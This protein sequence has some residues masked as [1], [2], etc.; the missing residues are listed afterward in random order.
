MVLRDPDA[1]EAE[2]V[3]EA[4][5][6]QGARVEIGEGAPAVRGIAEVIDD[7]EAERVAAVS[8]DFGFRHRFG[9]AS[10]RQHQEL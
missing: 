6:L 1:V 10:H 9:V 7:A 2:L 3:D 8:G 5:L 4:N